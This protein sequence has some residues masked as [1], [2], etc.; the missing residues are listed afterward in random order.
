MNG[1]AAGGDRAAGTR[2]AG[3]PATARGGPRR[4]PQGGGADGA[5]AQHGRAAAVRHRHPVPRG[6][7]AALLSLAVELG[8]RLR[9]RRQAAEAITMT[10]TLAGR[11]QVHRSRHLPGGPTAH[12]E[13]LRDTAYETSQCHCQAARVLSRR[14][15]AA[16]STLAAIAPLR[17]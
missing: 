7:R 14:N 16:G 5:A 11:S 17:R 9:T 1:P 12:T 15:Y 2:R 4:R 10:V 13:D 3:G 6:S 8:D